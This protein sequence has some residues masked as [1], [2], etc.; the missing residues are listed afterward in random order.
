MLPILI[1]F[2]ILI[3]SL[4][5]IDSSQITIVK[6]VTMVMAISIA[7]FTDAFMQCTSQPL[8]LLHSYKPLFIL[9]LRVCANILL[10]TSIIAYIHKLSQI[11]LVLLSIILI[12]I[13]STYYLSTGHRTYRHY[14]SN[15]ALLITLSSFL[16][17]CVS[18][19]I[20]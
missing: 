8:N 19:S 5:L 15:M 9:C 3:S 12:L 16:S 7:I 14:I 18:I 2:N 17:I 10:I 6:L 11:I 1:E 13:L 20:N 4:L